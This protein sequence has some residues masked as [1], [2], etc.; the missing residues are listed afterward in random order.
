M[1]ER[2]G[3][4]RL[5]DV[6]VYDQS[7]DGQGPG[8]ALRCG[9]ANAGANESVLVLFA[10]TLIDP[11]EIPAADHWIGV[12]VTGERRSWCHVAEGE[13]AHFI[14]GVPDHTNA[15]AFIGALRLPDANRAYEVVAAVNEAHNRTSA[16][17]ELPMAPV[18]NVLG[19]EL[20]G[21]HIAVF[22]SW[23][24]V[25]DTRALARAR[26]TEFIS[27]EHHKL[28]LDEVGIITKHNASFAQRRFLD[29]LP[30]R[31]QPLFPRVHGLEPLRMDYV[32]LPSLAELWLYW[33]GTTGMWVD[34]I[35][36]LL[37]RVDRYLWASDATDVGV[38]AEL[39]ARRMYVD[40][41]RQRLQEV[42]LIG[43]RTTL[44][45][46]HVERTLVR[47]AA[48][49]PQT[50]IH[51]DLNLGNVLWSL[52]TGTFKLLDPR[53]DWGD[54][55]GHGDLVY[56]LAKLRYD[57]RHGFS[58]IVHGLYREEANGSFTLH[59]PVAATV[60]ALDDVLAEHASLE[61]VATAE[62]T[63][64]LSALPLHPKEQWGPM[65]QQAH[66]LMNEV[67]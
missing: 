45:L 35:G 58:A 55:T 6:T 25:G 27:R 17:C 61:L 56:E 12:G 16:G 66:K 54:G 21:A 8:H 14:E 47:T 65:L 32:D 13:G 40:K 53:G 48:R 5:Y 18:L 62:A 37:E 36:T 60:D 46:E 29:T 10:D 9:L 42:G 64:F 19:I 50:L 23:L 39:R 30:K 7:S 1:L 49:R 63:L 51:G 33:P 2:S 59:Q 44:F 34:I 4:D 11:K 20:E 3:L 28:E 38:G 26:R 24:D 15:T 67:M 52:S 31:A 41:T 57:Y 22:S 43:R